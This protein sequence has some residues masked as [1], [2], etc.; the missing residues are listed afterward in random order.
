MFVFENQEDWC[1]FPLWVCLCICKHLCPRFCCCVCVCVGGACV[2]ACMC[3]RVL[4]LFAKCLLAS[5]SCGR[6]G[7]T[8]IPLIT[9]T[10]AADIH[11]LDSK[12]QC[13]GKLW[14]TGTLAKYHN[15]VMKAHP[16]QWQQAQ[17]HR[18]M[19]TNLNVQHTG[20]CWQTSMCSTQGDADKPQCAAH[21]AMPTNLN[22]QHHVLLHSSSKVTQLLTTLHRCSNLNTSLPWNNKSNQMVTGK[23]IFY[24]LIFDWFSVVFTL[25]DIKMP[26]V[27]KWM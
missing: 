19:P 26:V 16:Q 27:A 12:L 23:R 10:Y 11:V 18:A 13:L 25:F 3:I 21:R 6:W 7:A 20:R 8:E 9:I 15:Q 5:T 17:T 22:V 2:H 1:S 14:K 4:A 24:L